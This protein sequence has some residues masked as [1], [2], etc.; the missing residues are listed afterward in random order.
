MNKFVFQQCDLESY[1][2]EKFGIEYKQLQKIASWTQT[3]SCFLEIPPNVFHE[4]NS[5][6]DEPVRCLILKPEGECGDC[7]VI[8]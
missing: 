7:Y 3:D 6:Y 4:L 2:A 5:L 1:Y 8:R